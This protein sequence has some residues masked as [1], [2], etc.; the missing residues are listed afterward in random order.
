MSEGF[1]LL[2]SG[3]FGEAKIF[4]GNFLENDPENPTALIC[5]GR[6][7]GLS[8][9]VSES[10]SIFQRLLNQNPQ[11]EEVLLNMAES[12][13]WGNDGA[14]AAAVYSDILSSNPKNFVALMG[15]ANSM[16][17]Q[18][19]YDEAYTYIKKAL[20]INPDNQQARISRKFIRLGLADYLAS[21]KGDYTGAKKLVNE[22]LTANSKDQESLMLKATIHLLEGSFAEARDIYEH[23]IDNKVQAYKGWCVAEHFLGADE[24]ALEVV[25][26][27]IEILSEKGTKEDK[28]AMQLQYVTALLWNNE[29]K[30]ASEFVKE[31]RQTYPENKEVIAS[32]AE[33]LIYFSDY[34]GG[35]SKYQEYLGYAPKSFKGNLGM[36][37]ANHAL[38]LDHLAYQGAFKTLTFYPGQKDVL[39]FIDRL[40]DG[41]APYIGTEGFLSETSD[42]SWRKRLTSYSS[43]S[44]GP[45]FKVNLG[46]EHELF[47]DAITDDIADANTFIVGSSYRI[48]K[49]T[50]VEANIDI[51]SATSETIDLDFLNYKVQAS[52]R[53]SKSQQVIVA[54][55]RE[56]QNF[57]KALLE[58]DIMMDHYILKNISFWK[59]PKIG[60]YSEYYYTQF[61]DGNERSLLFT[62]VY[63]NLL[64]KPLLKTGIN[65]STMTFSRS[66]PELYYSPE[67]FHNIEWFAGFKKDETEKFKLAISADL[68]VGYQFSDGQEQPAWRVNVAFEK[69]IGR[70]QM[71]LHGQ[72]N[73][74]SAVTNNGFSF[75]GIGLAIK[76]RIMDKPVFYNKF[77]TMSD[78]IQTTK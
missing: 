13:L 70:L 19:K 47:G 34:S 73:S 57:N 36:A 33:V 45:L 31:L 60:W 56:I 4:F 37:D 55:E 38:G 27:G 32:E 22:N 61:S 20:V 63:R 3:Q 43:L 44:L 25:K 52:F 35:V 15:Y 49:L 8:G 9:N 78:R 40:N 2:E 53:L 66:V 76:Y 74:I 16:S 69:E 46:Y 67:K 75:S 71:K 58:L 41:H 77:N 54:H 65:Y 17:M 72:H 5:Y 28:L 26:E 7:T 30:D 68:A 42:G 23:R 29:L 14:S 11:S 1:K 10:Q 62:S 51:T 59:I 21:Q 48:N 18:K 6:A 64:D 39:G 50:L 12:H 24:R